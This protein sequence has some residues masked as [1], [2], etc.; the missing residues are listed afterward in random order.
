MTAP[1]RVQG[2]RLAVVTAAALVAVVAVLLLR[3]D[4]TVETPPTQGTGTGPVGTPGP[5]YLQGVEQVPPTPPEES[6]ESDRPCARIFVQRRGEPATAAVVQ[7]LHLP[8]NGSAVSVGS[9]RRVDADGVARFTLPDADRLDELKVE[10]VELSPGGYARALVPLDTASVRTGSMQSLVLPVGGFLVVDIS[11]LPSAARPAHV[12]LRYFPAT[13]AHLELV[14]VIPPPVPKVGL[15]QALGGRPLHCLIN[16]SGRTAPIEIPADHVVVPSIQ[17][18]QEGWI[19]LAQEYT[20]RHL[21]EPWE[22]PVLAIRE[23]QHEIYEPKW[24]QLPQIEIRVADA[25]NGMPLAGCEIWVGARPRNSARRRFVQ[26]IVADSSGWGRGHLALGGMMPGWSLDES[27]IVVVAT[28]TGYRSQVS[29]QRFAWGTIRDD[30][31]LVR[32][33]GLAWTIRGRVTWKS[34]PP[35]KNV[36]LVVSPAS[37]S[38]IQFP[39]TT[40][41]QGQFTL[42]LG[43]SDAPLFFE[44]GFGLAQVTPVVRE[45]RTEDGRVFRIGFEPDLDRAAVRLPQEPGPTAEVALVLDRQLTR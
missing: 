10:A 37:L 35:A 44:W 43:E 12:E 21:G 4:P 6:S 5:P 2:K 39:V 26:R 36:D 17:P 1:V 20:G 29:V 45:E 15:Q 16:E 8:A 14:G 22:W 38:G 11:G 34:G 19:V 32:D 25:A 7:I 33:S 18:V 42:R 40:D 41:A 28:A 30:L 13:E 24:G 27:D 31:N 9:P 3:S 23:G